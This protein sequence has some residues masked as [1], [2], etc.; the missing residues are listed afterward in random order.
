MPSL[1]P[2]MDP[3]L[4]DPTLWRGVHQSLITYIR[5]NMQPL[6]RPKHHAH[7]GERVYLLSPPRTVCPDITLIEHPLK[8]PAPGGTLPSAKVVDLPYK[9]KALD[10]DIREPYIEI[11]HNVRGEVVTVSG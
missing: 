7:I 3:Y 9:L 6:L 8:E 11:V 5:D 2:G 4:E 10:I 1:F